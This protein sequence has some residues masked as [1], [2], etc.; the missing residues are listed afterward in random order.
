MRLVNYS[1]NTKLWCKTDY[2]VERLVPEEV[3]KKVAGVF[4]TIIRRGET[5]IA[6]G[7]AIERVIK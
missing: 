2:D 4:N 6:I 5:V 7:L 3:R 1:I